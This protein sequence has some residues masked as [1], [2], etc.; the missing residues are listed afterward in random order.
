LEGNPTAQ[1]E[2][3]RAV[4]LAY[5]AFATRERT[6]AELRT[7]LELKRVEP[8]A[9]EVAV[10]ELTEAGIVDDARFAQLFAHDKRDLQRWGSER[11]AREL[12]RRGVAPDLIEQTLVSQQRSD[13]LAQAVELVRERFDPP[14]DERERD[15]AWRLLVR[16]GYEPE[17]AYEAV[18]IA[19]KR[20]AA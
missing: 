20:E 9:I 8:S 10:Q 5:R 15:R 14:E 16:R 12:R 19:G 17:L 11:I 7:Y 13:E 3:R 2:D 18:R 6:T 1:P 4:E